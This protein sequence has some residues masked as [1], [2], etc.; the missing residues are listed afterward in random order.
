MRTLGVD[1]SSQAAK[2]AI[3]CIQWSTD[4]ATVS[5]LRL[6]VSD[7]V[8]LDLA[9]ALRSAKSEA[10]VEYAVGID[11]PFGWPL[12]FI[13]FIGRSRPSAKPLPPWSPKL[14]RNFATD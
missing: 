9:M 3:C 13:E 8:I 5:D 14:A 11:A 6:G 1:L 2:T 12:P 4:S 7:E 10:G